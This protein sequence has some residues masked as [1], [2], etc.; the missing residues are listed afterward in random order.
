MDPS[1]RLFYKLLTLVKLVRFEIMDS[2][3]PLAYNA[4]A[5][6]AYQ[7]NSY[8]R[9]VKGSMGRPARSMSALWGRVHSNRDHVALSG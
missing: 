8:I 9:Y 7:L 2:G 1:L 3:R 4:P 6:G 5:S